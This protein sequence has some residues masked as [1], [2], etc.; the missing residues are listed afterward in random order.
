MIKH[1]IKRLIL[2]TRRQ[3]KI[4][5]LIK[6]MIKRLILRT[7]QQRKIKRLITRMIKRIIKHMINAA[8]ATLS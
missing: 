4:K 5:R 6:H 1:M 8:R 2:R 3:R 7:R